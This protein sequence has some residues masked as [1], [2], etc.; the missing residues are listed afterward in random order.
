MEV[1]SNEYKYDF[2]PSA[3]DWVA[4]NVTINVEP[5]ASGCET[6]LN[7]TIVGALISS[8]ATCIVPVNISGAVC[9]SK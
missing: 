4:G 9:A 3:S 2:R 1:S 8:Q 5:G 6:D 7:I